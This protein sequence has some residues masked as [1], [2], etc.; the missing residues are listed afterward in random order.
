[1]KKNSVTK[2]ILALFLTFAFVFPSIAT[3]QNATKAKSPA[4]AAAET[5]TAGQL[6]DYLYFV[7]SDEMEGRDT[8]S[9]GLDLT[10]KFIGTMLSRWGFKPAGD[11]GTFFQKIA[12]RRDVVDPAK[13]FVEVG[14]QK[15]AYGDDLMRV[16]GSDTG[17][18]SAPIVY[19]GNGWMIKSKNLN[20]YE[21]IDVKG[22]FIAVYSEGA[23][24]SPQ[25]IVPL[26]E[27]I[28]MADLTGDRGNGWADPATYARQNGAAGVIVLPS[29]FLQENWLTLKQFFGRTRTYVEKLAGPVNVSRPSTS[30]FIASNKLAKAIF[31]NETQNPLTNTAKSSFALNSG[32]TVNFNIALTPE[33][34]YTQNVVALWE[35]GDP[36]LK[37]EMVA[38]GAHY[39]H[40]GVNP[41]AKGDDKIWNGADDDGSGTVSV[42]AIAEALAKAPKRPKRSILLVWHAGEE[43]GLWG[44]E[45]FNKFPTVDIKQV[46][47][48]LNID[49]IGRSRKAGDTNPKNANLSGESEV[50]VIGSEMMSSK[51]GE[52][53][54]A[55]N[56]S[57]LKL[58]YDF[59]YDDPKDTNRFFFRSDH[60]NY[61]VNGI[62]I[63]FWFDGVH[64]DYHQPGD[65]AEKI[66]YQKMEK[67][68]RTIFLTAWELTDLKERPAIDKQLPPEL[69]QR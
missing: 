27:G 22:K 24:T 51:L 41:N 1:M 32:K 25:T 12:L 36:K 45:Y 6:K 8:P 59:K 28:T 17:A 57:Y 66:D 26:P 60:F 15:F 37:D 62:P 49:M 61:A 21:G 38:V 39:D 19:A 5:I 13:S 20:P 42:L 48:Q 46:I 43:K 52:I 35:G 44:S 18:I 50:F 64:E 7:A 65:E 2:N 16:S 33:I 69:M 54:R 63:V 3:A 31:D 14:G 58:K 29:K 30:V 4:R 11:N 55:T 10:A 47:A 67:I 40:V 68:A 34:L 23:I 9:R 56:D 53:T